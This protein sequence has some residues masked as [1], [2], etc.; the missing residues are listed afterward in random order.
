[1]KKI[2]IFILVV[3]CAGLT[4]CSMPAAATQ[5]QIYSFTKKEQKKKGLFVNS[6][7]SVKDFREIDMYTED[8]DAL[9]EEVEKYIAAHPELNEDTK[10]NIRQLK[11]APGQS[12]EEVL[13]LLGEPDKISGSDIWIYRINKWRA[14]TVFIIPVFFVREGYYLYFKDDVLTDIERHYLKQMIRQ[15][16][17][18]GVYETSS[19]ASGSESK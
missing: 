14:F 5:G 3:S 19:D 1:M 18:S 9:K 2:I 11:V 8:I 4:G 17:G 13:L 6:Y 12:K 10:K 15:S 16:A 7:E